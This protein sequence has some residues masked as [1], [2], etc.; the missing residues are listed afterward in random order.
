MGGDNTFPAQPERQLLQL[1]TTP[2]VAPV[3]SSF[4]SE[5][6]RGC[7]VTA[8]D[9]WLALP[10]ARG[11]LSHSLCIGVQDDEAPHGDLQKFLNRG[12]RP[13][14]KQSYFAVK[15][16]VPVNI[17]GAEYTLHIDARIA[18]IKP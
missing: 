10:P 4:T 16:G 1:H 11:S 8:E 12:D 13:Y 15:I 7:T 9:S 5:G 3:S 17:V 2:Q 18:T 14:M 6:F